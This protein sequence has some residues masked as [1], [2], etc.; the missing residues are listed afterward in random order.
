M[1]R[2]RRI[3]ATIALATAATTG[4]LLTHDL[5]AAPAADTAWGNHSTLDTSI[6]VTTEPAIEGTVVVTPLDTAWG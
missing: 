6:I 4:A 2:L 1:K 5:A 3:T